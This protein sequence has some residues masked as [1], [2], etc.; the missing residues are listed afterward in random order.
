MPNSFSQSS[1]DKLFDVDYR[2]VAV[3]CEALKL[4]D[5]T[6]VC[7]HRG[8]LEQDKA[9]AE[10]KSKK[11]FPDSKHNLKPSKAVDIAP[12]PI[13]WDDRERFVL[14]AGLVIGIGEAKGYVIRW[15]GAWNGLSTIKSNKFNDLPHFEIVG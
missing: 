3:L 2:L 13:D 7:G 8:K 15:G 12:Y 11:K 5:F 14:L 4:L 1:L 10:G 9:F 6:V